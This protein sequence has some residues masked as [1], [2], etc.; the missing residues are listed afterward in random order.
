MREVSPSYLVRFLVFA[1]FLV[2]AK[3][4]AKIKR[5]FRKN[6]RVNKKSAHFRLMQFQI[7]P[8]ARVIIILNFLTL[9][10]L[11]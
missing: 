1:K 2:K 7:S 4:S 8:T 9:L 6:F 3:I 5:K 11:N 10:H